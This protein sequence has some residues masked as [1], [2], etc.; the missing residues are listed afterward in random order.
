MTKL[1]FFS[2][3]SETD[4]FSVTI[5]NS[6]V[7]PSPQIKSLGIILDSTLSFHSHI[8]NITRSAYLHLHNL[9]PFLTPH[10][11]SILVY[12]L[13]SS[14]L[15]YCNSLLSGVTHKS[16]YKLQLVQNSAARIITR[17]PF[18]HHITRVLQQLHWRPINFKF[19]FKSSS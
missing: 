15:D 2:T 11:T 1:R 9:R 8:N 7:F 17:T 16:L 4:S 3:I 6:T 18:I 5:D 13:V 14:R 19:N 10:T 12:S